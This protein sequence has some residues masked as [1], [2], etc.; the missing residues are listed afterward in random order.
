M[1]LY[2]MD[3]YSLGNLNHL[4]IQIPATAQTCSEAVNFCLIFLTNFLPAGNTND[5]KDA[6]VSKSS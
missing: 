6:M 4:A 1:N 5:L 2:C 3:L